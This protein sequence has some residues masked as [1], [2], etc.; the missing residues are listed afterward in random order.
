MHNLVRTCN[1]P[2]IWRMWKPTI[3]DAILVTRR[4]VG[5]DIFVSSSWKIML[6]RSDTLKG[7]N[8]LS[9]ILRVKAIA[10]AQPRQNVIGAFAYSCDTLFVRTT[11]NRQRWNGS[12]C[13]L[14]R[15]S[16]APKTSATRRIPPLSTRCGRLKT[17]AHRR[18]PPHLGAN[19][20]SLQKPRGG[21][22]ECLM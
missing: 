3:Y 21:G 18:K 14:H 10:E 9:E 4:Y 6:T 12:S 16:G 8:A 11:R 2:T 1:S 15:S 22:C 17:S 7:Q 5:V 13:L 20:R 19:L